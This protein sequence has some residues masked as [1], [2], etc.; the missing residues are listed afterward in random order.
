MR[1]ILSTLTALLFLPLLAPAQSLS[2]ATNGHQ[3]YAAAL[4]PLHT[5]P[6]LPLAP[7]WVWDVQ[8]VAIEQVNGLPGAGV[9]VDVRHM[10]GSWFG[11]LGVGGVQ[12]SGGRARCLGFLGVGISVK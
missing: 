5:G 6:L 8:A 1:L 11:F 2:L 4:T 12:V 7:S 10:W 3:T 9:E